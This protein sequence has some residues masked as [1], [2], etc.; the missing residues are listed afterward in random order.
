MTWIRRLALPALL[1]VL[2]LGAAP[3]HATLRVESHSTGLIVQDKNG[4]G[5]TV[6]ITAATQGGD[7]VYLIE[8][9][10]TSLDFFKFDFGPNCSEGAVNTKAV[11]KRLS[12]KLNLAMGGGED[13]LQ[14]GSSGATSVS[15][16]LGTFDDTYIGIGGPD[17]VFASDGNDDVH[18]GGG[19]D[20]IRIGNGADKV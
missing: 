5:S 15:A 20:D 12:G 2:C 1:A 16:N 3:A 4:F 9:L 14:V 7:P 10:D 6:T 17:N 11:C 18:T 8:H 13:L 19:D